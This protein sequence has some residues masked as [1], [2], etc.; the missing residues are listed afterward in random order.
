MRPCYRRQYW[1]GT[2][3]PANYTFSSANFSTCSIGMAPSH[4]QFFFLADFHTVLGWHRLG[5]PNSPQKIIESQQKQKRSMESCYKSFVKNAKVNKNKNDQSSQKNNLQATHQ[6]PL[7]PLAAR[8]S[9][10]KVQN[11]EPNKLHNAS[12]PCSRQSTSA[13]ITLSRDLTIR[14]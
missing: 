6:S 7:M 9:F 11:P 14:R 10:S 13:K 12:K 2:F 3:S 4:Q 5:L 8:H 1:D